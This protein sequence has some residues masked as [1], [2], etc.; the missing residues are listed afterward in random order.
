MVPSVRA[1]ERVE[2]PLGSQQDDPRAKNL[3]LF[4]RRRPNSRFK[5]RTIPWRQPDFRSF[6]EHHDVESRISAP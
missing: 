6:G 1:I 2:H 5:H 4:R 3:A